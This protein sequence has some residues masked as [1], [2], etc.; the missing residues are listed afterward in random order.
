[1]CNDIYCDSNGYYHLV[2]M[3]VNKINNKI[4]IGKH[5]TNNLD[6]GYMGS[7]KAINAAINK[8]G[9][10]NFEKVIIDCLPTEDEAYLK[11]EDI[12]TS[13]F[14]DREDTYNQ[15]CGGKGNKSCDMLGK[16]NPMYG[17]THS[18]ETRK[19]F[20]EAKKGKYI[21]E[22]NPNYGNGD[23]IKGKKNPMYGKT[24]SIETRKKLSEM[25]KGEKHPFSKAVQKIDIDGNIII[26]YQTITECRKMEHISFRNLVKLITNNYQR[27][28]YYY[29][30]KEKDNE[31]T[32]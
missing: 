26:E 18:I 12:V 1:M 10:H 7:G 9:T 11:E 14:V 5:T 22:A 23:K 27:H 17:K 2:Y 13:E 20:S 3:I 8:Y 6:D 32:T 15:K 31:Q 30:Y 25:N 29:R 19:K 24:H 16:K 4:Y 28:G 21:G